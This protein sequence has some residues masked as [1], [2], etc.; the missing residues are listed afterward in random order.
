MKNKK[1]V[2]LVGLA[3]SAIVYLVVQGVAKRLAMGH[4]L[5]YQVMSLIKVM[6][7]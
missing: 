4:M 5:I 6:N 3:L 7:M 2:V 1:L